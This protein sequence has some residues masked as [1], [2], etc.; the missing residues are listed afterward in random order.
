[1][2]SDYFGD[3]WTQVRLCVAESHKPILTISQRTELEK[4]TREW[5]LNK[6]GPQG[7]IDSFK[8][9]FYLLLFYYF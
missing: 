4:H 1:M 8:I 5:W 6:S 9:L 3:K 2:G 7:E